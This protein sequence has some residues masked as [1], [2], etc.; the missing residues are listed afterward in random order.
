MSTAQV[1]H[2]SLLHAYIAEVLTGYNSP[3]ARGSGRAL[4]NLGFGTA[5]TA[6]RNK[7]ILD[8]I[9]DEEILQKQEIPVV[10]TSTIG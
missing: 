10:I 5:T 9:E 1:K 7:G 6:Q 8:D 3:N 2:A 4:G